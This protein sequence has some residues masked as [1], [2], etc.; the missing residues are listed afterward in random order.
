MAGVF[1]LSILL[2]PL[3]AGAVPDEPEPASPD[4]AAPASPDAATPAPAGPDA[5]AAESAGPE[6]AGA[7]A[8]GREAAARVEAQRRAMEAYFRDDPFSPLRAFARF[9]F[10]LG[11][12]ASAV[13]GSG[14]EADVRLR[15]GDAA[16]RLAR[17]T[18]LEP[19]A[20][21]GPHR[22]L[23]ESLGP[24]GALV[25]N[26]APLGAAGEPQGSRAVPE[27]SRV[28]IGPYAIRPYV[29]AGAGI[30]IL[31][32][33]RLT[34]EGRFAPP[35]HFPY[36]PTFR[37]EAALQ[38][39]DEPE[40]IAL[41]TTLERTKEYRR[42]GYFDLSIGGERLRVNTYQPLFV[43]GA[44]EALTILFSDRTSGGETYGSGRYIDL[45][46][47]SGGLYT[48]DFNRA[49]NP[50]CNYTDVYNCPVPPGENRLPVAVRAGE[51]VWRPPAAAPAAA[52]PPAGEATD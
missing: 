7:D 2:A 5:A 36:D 40:T 6:S 41:P 47:P 44:G 51:M 28:E 9:D 23:W 39:F 37:F 1:A 31:F 19:Q 12:G 10:P 3:A 17:V 20:P 11:A 33:S 46:P 18:V 25:V 30:L 35:R 43:P 15:P 34:A 50:Y 8:A 48:I 38:R 26:G 4:A 49:Y 42:V 13:I 16:P 52:P 24:G 22:F 32:D 45:D 27:E 14:E 29:Q 21:G